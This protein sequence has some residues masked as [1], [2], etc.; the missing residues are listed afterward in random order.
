MKMNDKALDK[1]LQALIGKIEPDEL[2]ICDNFGC[3]ER[4]E[5]IRCLYDK[6]PDCKL[7]REYERHKKRN[8]YN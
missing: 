3:I 7:Y 4:G 1:L 2:I 6:Y 5:Y 8:S